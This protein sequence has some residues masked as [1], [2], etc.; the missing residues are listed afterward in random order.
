V[1]ATKATATTKTC[2]YVGCGATFTRDPSREGPGRWAARRFCNRTCMGAARRKNPA[3]PQRKPR[4]APVP[5]PRTSSRGAWRP[6]APGWP[7]EPHIPAH[8]RRTPS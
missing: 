5:A 4:P 1:T 3:K 7:A 8:L 6:N 2:A